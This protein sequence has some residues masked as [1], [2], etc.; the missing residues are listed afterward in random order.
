M[1]LAKWTTVIFIPIL[2]LASFSCTKSDSTKYASKMALV[3]KASSNPFFARMEE[4]AKK[5]ADSLNVELLVGTI[6]RETDINQ[7]VSLI[8]NM[9]VQGV[10]AILIAPADSKAIVNVLKKAQDAG[11]RVVNIDNRIDSET[12]K[13]VGLTIDCFV[14]VDNQQGGKMAGDYLVGLMGGKGQAAML[15]GIRG[16]DNAEARKNGFLQ[17]LEGTDVE[18][19]ASQSANWA[20]DQGLDIFANMLQANPDITGLFCAND[21]MA[22]GAIQAIEQAGKTGKIFVTSYDNLQA[23]QEAI[24]QGRLNG[25]IEQH[26][27]RMGFQGVMVANELLQGREVKPEIMIALEL[28]TRETLQK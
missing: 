7:Q 27:E 17:A 20:Q 16:V 6:T 19:V 28:I 9:I 15:E 21:M 26:P 13:A 1:R 2:V 5:A 12:A 3:M 4:G 25:T 10:Q 11:I 18:L 24:L 8:E 14:G 23:A 22:L